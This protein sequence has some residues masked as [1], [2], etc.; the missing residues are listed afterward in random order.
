MPT[1]G[2]IECFSGEATDWKAY[3]E[4]LEAY[5]S[6]NNIPADKKVNT[7]ITVIGQTTYKLLT[8]LCAPATP[9]SLT[10]DT[11]KKKLASHFTPKPLLI[12]ERFRFHKRD[13][14]HGE[15]IQTYL[16]ELRRLAMT[17]DFGNTLEDT[18]RDRLVCGLNN[19]HIQKRLLAEDKLTLQ[20]AV[21]LAVAMDAAHKDAIEL[22]KSHNPNNTNG[23]KSDVIHAAKH[24]TERFSKKPKA[25][26]S[27]K[28]TC[29]NCGGVYPHRQAP[30]PAADKSCHHC[31]RKGHFA[32]FCRADTKKKANYVSEEP[33]Y[34]FSNT[35][36][37]SNSRL[38]AFGAN[39]NLIERLDIR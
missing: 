20:K 24:K 9:G 11:L 38:M 28:S 23:G 36:T 13:Q 4:R 34:A 17:C 6:A 27:Q 30:C 7:L 14:H 16:A 21:E 32:K 2:K 5:I 12:A 22:Q 8:N 15:P 26:F 33:D 10:Y 29:R 35:T 19:S 25:K 39:E 3:A 1:I 31:S 18:L 37:N